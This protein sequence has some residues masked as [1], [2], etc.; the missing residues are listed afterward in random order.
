MHEL[1][2]LIDRAWEKRAALD[3]A[4]AGA[5]RAPLDEV[6]DPDLGRSVR[7]L[8]ALEDRHRTAAGGLLAGA[9]GCS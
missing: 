2:S 7:D 4:E 8:S 5:L 3:S 1:E 6:M 9:G